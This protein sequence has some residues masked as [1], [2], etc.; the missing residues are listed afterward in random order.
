MLDEGAELGGGTL[1]ELPWARRQLV[2]VSAAAC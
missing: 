2:R 1:S